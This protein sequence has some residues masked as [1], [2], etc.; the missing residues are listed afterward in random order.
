MDELP[1]VMLGIRTAW[2]EDVG[3][4][5]ADLVYGTGLH[6]PGELFEAPRTTTLAPGFL[7][8]L[9]ETMRAL[10][11][12]QPKYHGKQPTRLPSSLGHT[13]Y[14]YVRQ[15]CHRGPLQRPYAG[16]FRVV[17]KESKYFVVEI[18]GRLDKISVDRLKTAYSADSHEL[19]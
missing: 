17:E 3:C 15:D 8:D 6:L 1:M 5:P 14:V 13:G 19:P 9:Q 2:R 10:V 16:P 11:P 12:P 4:S 7:R 18:N